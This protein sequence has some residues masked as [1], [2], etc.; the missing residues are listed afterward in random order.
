[1]AKTLYSTLALACAF[2]VSVHAET[3]RVDGF[4]DYQRAQVLRAVNEA[5]AMG[6]RFRIVDSGPAD[7]VVVA[8]DGPFNSPRLALT[9]GK[10]ALVNMNALGRR[11]LC[12]VVRHELGHVLG[13]EHD[14]HG[15]MQAVYGPGTRC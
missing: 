8:W 10:T 4:T 9:V 6:G 14:D 7:T 2:S 1:M 3:I 12:G 11:D 5:N 13:L 15:P